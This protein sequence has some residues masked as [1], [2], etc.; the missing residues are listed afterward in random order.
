MPAPGNLSGLFFV[1]FA[2]LAPAFAGGKPVKDPATVIRSAVEASDIWSTG[3]VRLR[4]RVKFLQVQAGM[5][6]AEYE[7]VWIS[8]KRWRAQLSSLEFNEVSV[9]G[10][11]RVWYSASAPDKPL[12]VREFGRALAALSQTVVGQGLRYTWHERRLTGQKSK[13]NC[14][15]VSDR[16]RLLVQ[17][18][19]DPD[20]GLLLLA[21]DFAATWVYTYSDYR[22]FAGKLFPHTI[23]AFEGRT[24]VVAA[25][26]IDL[27]TASAADPTLFEAPPGAEVY[28]A[29]P[30]ALGFPLGAK[31]GR[32]VKQVNPIPPHLLP[33]HNILSNDVIISGVIG[34]DGNLHNLVAFGSNSLT[35]DAALEAVRQ[36]RYEP[37]TV[38]GNPVE[39]PTSFTV[40]FATRP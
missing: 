33:S 23:L 19:V 9:G 36:W 15:E 31:P 32:L 28:N 37:F 34:R 12:R 13:V 2:A 6:D 38:C 4:V 40:N 14:V 7:K 27:D 17:D 20:T 8:P 25:Q 16:E 21:A 29:C 39:M 24:L 10:D 22:P 30:E 11:G 18:C 35:K 1:L 3:T 5:I 26:V